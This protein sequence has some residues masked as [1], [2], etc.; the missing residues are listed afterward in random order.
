MKA[1]VR[2][3]FGLPRDVLELREV[4]APEP[5]DDGVLLRVRAASVNALD[6]YDATGTPW[7]ARP[8]AGL[9]RPKDPSVGADVAGTVEAVGRGV[10]DLQPGDDVYGVGSG[11][12]AEHARASAAKIARTPSGLTFE[13]AAAVPVAGCTALQG[14]RD[15]GQL[16]AGQSV[17]VNGASGG[18]G[19]FTVQIARALGA[20]VTAVCSTRNVEQARSLGADYVVDYSREDFARG[21]ARYDL[22]VDIAGGRSWAQYRRVLKPDGTL[23]LVGAKGNR[24]LG[25]LGHIVRV[26][27]ASVPGGRKALF[28]V[29]RPSRPD[30]DA[31][32]QLL[33]SGAV[34]A[35]V[36]QRYELADAGAAVQYVGEGHAR[37][38]VVV[39]V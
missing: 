28:F 38:K 32:R 39:T 9:V 35:I 12:F 4:H 22:I 3:R 2:E 37:G 31:L 29:A 23:L 6:W 14:L 27:L 21:A 26:R 20:E 13:E 18:V 10:S 33:E 30:L 16:Q 36:E 5:A 17:L 11:T 34:K 7:I 8:M 24:L 19:T 15:H 25:P 1:I